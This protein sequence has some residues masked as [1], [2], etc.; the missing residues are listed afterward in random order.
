MKRTLRDILIKKRDSIDAET[1][2]LKEQAIR[3]RLIN[4]KHFKEAE[5]ILFYASFRSEVDTMRCMEHSLKLGKRI[6]LPV[7]DRVHKRLRPYEIKDISELITNYMGIPEPV[8]SRTRI[9]KM[10]EIDLIIVPGIGFDPMGS[11]LGY[12]AGYYDRFLAY[13]KD[14][15]IRGHIPTIA[16]AFEE[17]IVE[18]IHSEPHDIKVDIIITDKRTISCRDYRM[19]GY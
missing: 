16:L 14:P 17:Q 13:K 15:G 11:R 9:I 12:G 1:R 8:T 2:R 4:T 6:A 7:I 3:N 5:T 18:R 10:D 19:S